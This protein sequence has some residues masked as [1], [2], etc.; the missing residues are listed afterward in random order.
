MGH[1]WWMIL[2][3][4]LS[5]CLV[6]ADLWPESQ[7][8]IFLCSNLLPSHFFCRYCSQK[9]SLLPPS[10]F[11]FSLLFPPLTHGYCHFSLRIVSLTAGCLFPHTCGMCPGL[12]HPASLA[13]LA[14][15][16]N[17]WRAW[18]ARRT[19]GTSRVR[20]WQA[21]EPL[22]A[23][24]PWRTPGGPGKPL[25]HPACGPGGFGGEPLAG[26]AG[27]ANPWWPANPWRTSGGP[28]EPLAAPMVWAWQACGQVNLG[29]LVHLGCR[30]GGPG[31]LMAAHISLAHPWRA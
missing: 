19:S 13:G 17:P 7:L 1:L 15:P 23:A 26:L 12:V 2:T 30:P 20:A 3:Q 31:E 21:R 29:G 25:A 16:V 11:N 27:L 6:E 18:Q 4:E 14:G 9:Y 5:V 28:G 8:Y 10:F 22:V 24:N